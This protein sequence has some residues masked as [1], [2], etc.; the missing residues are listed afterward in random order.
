MNK[1][2]VGIIGIGTIGFAHAVCISENKIANMQLEAVCD[3]D[4]KRI[5]EFK[6]LYP[7]IKVY[8]DYRDLIASREVDAVV[9]AVPHPL[10]SEIAVKALESGLHVMLEKPADV[11]VSK[12]KILNEVAKRSQK[13][14]GIMF[15]QRTCPLFQKARDIVRGGLLGELKRTVWIVTNWYRTQHYYDSGS[16][17]A[18]WNGEGGGVLL[19]QAPH[20]LDL[21]QWICGMP[22]SVTAYCELAKFHNIEV[23]DDVTLFTKYENGATGT[24]ITSTGEYPGTNRLEISGTKG[25]LVVENNTLKWWKLN[26]DEREVCITSDEGF[27][28]SDCEYCEISLETKESSH[29]GILQNF[30]NAILFGEPLLSPGTDGIYELAISNAAYLSSFNGHIEV[31][32]PFNCEEFDMLLDQLRS[33]SNMRNSDQA[34]PV[35]KDYNKRWQV[36]W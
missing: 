28:D 16:W 31:P 36:R 11:S 2:K 18:T 7:N 10:H 15:N 1:V 13:V 8:K 27:S 5:C 6:K 3:I 30:T 25:K 17:R 33:N 29:Q 21:W 14:F 12:A 4:F 26:R 24:F 9:I 20:N 34:Q 22:C 23:E 32:L 19:N 35:S